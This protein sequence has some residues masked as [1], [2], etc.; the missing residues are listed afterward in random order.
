[1]GLINV[2]WKGAS[3][4]QDASNRLVTDSEKTTWNN[5]AN[6]SHT[7][8]KSQVGLGNVD[9]TADANKSVNYAT[10]AGATTKV[11]RVKHLSTAEELDGFAEANVFQYAT[12]DSIA[13][14]NNDGIIL[15]MTWKDNPKFAHQIYINDDDSLM[16]QR[17]R[18]NG[19]WSNWVKMIDSSNI[20]SQSVNY[21]NTSGSA[22]AVAWDNVS[23]KPSTFTPSAHN[24]D[25]AYLKLSGGTMTGR[26]TFSN[27]GNSYIFSGNSDSAPEVG[28]DKLGNLVISSWS[29]VSFTTSCE[30]QA[31]T[32]KTAVSIDCRNSIVKADYFKGLAENSNKLGGYAGSLSSV[33][34]T[35]VLRDSSNFVYLNYI[36]SDTQNNENPD[37]SQIIV[38]NGDNYYRKASLNHL[39]DWLVSSKVY[40]GDFNQHETY[41]CLGTAYLAQAGDY[42]LI[43]VASGQGYNSDV[44]QDL[45]YEI[46]LR[47]GNGNPV[48]YAGYVEYHTFILDNNVYVVQKSSTEYQIWIGKTNYTGKS[49]FTVE[50]PDD[51]KWVNGSA[52][53]TTV[54]DNAEKLPQKRIA[55]YSD[56]PTSLKNPNSLTIT[57]DG[58]DTGA[59]SADAYDGSSAKSISVSSSTH[60]HHLTY[61]KLTGGTLTGTLYSKLEPYGTTDQ[62][63]AHLGAY[64]SASTTENCYGGS[65]SI[66]STLKYAGI[67][68][69][70]FKS[71]GQRATLAGGVN[72]HHNQDKSFGVTISGTT[73]YSPYIKLT[74]KLINQNGYYFDADYGFVMKLG[75]FVPIGNKNT[76]CS[77]G[78]SSDK[79]KYIYATNGTIQTSNELKKNIIKDGID[80]RYEELYEKLEPIAFKWNNETADGNTHDRVHL[81]LGA[82][83]TKKH[84]DEVG[85]TAEEYALYC[86][87]IIKDEEGNDTGEKE[88]GI[89]YGQ[90]HALH[91]HMIQKL[92][93]KVDELETRL[94]EFENK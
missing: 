39:R 91:I 44:S 56:I 49:F 50:I 60:D 72:F 63:I 48:G 92:L 94:M 84:M 61:L 51:D 8:T 76:E 86:E 79:W 19:T 22:N 64:F 26:I 55:H 58:G 9:N 35:Y 80:N 41:C 14:I 71:S 67:R 53:Q 4:K 32:N 93:A 62:Y 73:Y 40:R 43:K 2:K 42:L 7:H 23:G 68:I 36:N 12:V 88:Y 1:M 70:Y 82:Q 46:H 24:H 33:A 66:V 6:S 69:G 31:Y 54:P 13:P 29:G 47:T 87:D 5:K 38:T 10:T 27:F 18:H 21:A 85:I 83:T 28:S 17:G 45:Q 89:N 3:L 37:I 78:G 16:M 81:G 57:V 11:T 30:D 25:T 75:N 52:T 15:S 90:L 59:T 65:L 77:I 74:A 34:S 20:G